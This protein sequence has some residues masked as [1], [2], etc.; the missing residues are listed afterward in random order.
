ME[1]QGKKAELWEP[2][3]GLIPGQGAQGFLAEVTLG[4]ELRPGNGLLEQH[5]GNMAVCWVPSKWIGSMLEMPRVC[6]P[7]CS[8]DS[9]MTSQVICYSA[10][11]HL[12]WA[13]WLIH[14]IQALGV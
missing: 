8:S 14:I 1:E 9:V 13:W 12:S 7:P 3:I 11:M 6:A 5:I 2:G 10:E 4:Y